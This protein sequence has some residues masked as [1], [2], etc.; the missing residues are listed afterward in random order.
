MASCKLCIT[1]VRRGLLL[2]YRN[3]TKAVTRRGFSFVGKKR[4]KKKK[5]VCKTTAICGPP[6]RHRSGPARAPA[7]CGARLL[8][9]CSMRMRSAPGEPLSRPHSSSFTPSCSLARL[10]PSSRVAL[11]RCAGATTPTRCARGPAYV[12][13]G[14]KHGNAGQLTDGVLSEVRASCM[15]CAQLLCASG[16]SPPAVG[17]E[18]NESARPYA[19]VRTGVC[20][21]ACAYSWLPARASPRAVFCK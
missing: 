11:C 17:S 18:Q 9:T 12:C 7:T 10:R 3:P 21:S 5:A 13:A 2:S 1:V 19:H 8:R 4:R 6:S 14:G 16:A 20:T 15:R